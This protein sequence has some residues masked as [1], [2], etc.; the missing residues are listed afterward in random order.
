[1]TWGTFAFQVLDGEETASPSF[2][3]EW[4]QKG[5]YFSAPLGPKLG[6]S[7]SSSNVDRNGTTEQLVGEIPN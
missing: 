1:M 4:S 7:A 5:S 6:T 3:R 2:M